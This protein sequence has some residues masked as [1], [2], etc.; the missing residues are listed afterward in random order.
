MGCPTLSLSLCICS[1]RLCLS[2]P[3]RLCLS[4]CLCTFLFVSE[5]VSLFVYSLLLLSSVSVSLWAV[6]HSLCLYL[7]S[8]NLS[9]CLS[10]SVCLSVCFSPS[11]RQ[12]PCL[13]DRCSFSVV[14]LSL[15]GL[16]YTISVSFYLQSLSLSVSLRL[17][18]CLSFTVSLRLRGNV[19][20]CLLSGATSQ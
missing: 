16:S 12:C 13:F 17:C 5:A 7:Q 3:L 11:P 18:P 14:S 20:V 6:M 8:L 15:C 9:V 4:V 2:V 10:Q 1:P 19:P